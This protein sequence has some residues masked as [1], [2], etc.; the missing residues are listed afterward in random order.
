MDMQHDT[1][2]TFNEYPCVY[3]VTF[4]TAVYL[5]VIFKDPCK[6]Y[7]YILKFGMWKNVNLNLSNN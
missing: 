6:I 4:D 3:V 2:N 1:S 7:A 5:K